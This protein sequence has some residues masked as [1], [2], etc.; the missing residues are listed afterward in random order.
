MSMCRAHRQVGMPT[1]VPA[2]GEE[3]GSIGYRHRL[4]HQITISHQIWPTQVASQPT[5]EIIRTPSSS[6]HKIWPSGSRALRHW[7]LHHRRTLC[8]HRRSRQSYPAIQYPDLLRNPIE[9]PCWLTIGDEVV[10]AIACDGEKG[11]KNNNRVGNGF[12]LGRARA[13]A[14]AWWASGRGLDTVQ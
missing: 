6:S 13:K 11:R 3:H 4:D 10:E 12:R 8:R 5:T 14:P 7:Y 1:Q 9:L 2:S